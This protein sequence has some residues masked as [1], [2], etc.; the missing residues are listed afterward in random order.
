MFVTIFATV[1]SG[2][3]VFVLGQILVKFVIEPVKE[4]KQV[5]GE[6]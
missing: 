5:L 3:L 6:I 1:I 2:V 4:L